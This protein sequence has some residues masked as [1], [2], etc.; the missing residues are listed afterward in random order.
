MVVV[1]P[2]AVERWMLCIRLTNHTAHNVAGF[3]GLVSGR[4]G[5]GREFDDSVNR[6]VAQ[7]WQD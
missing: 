6:K 3:G 2:A 1:L 7:P 5:D 4:P